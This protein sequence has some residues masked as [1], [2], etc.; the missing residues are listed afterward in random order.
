MNVIF[1][2]YLLNKIWQLLPEVF[3]NN[4]NII[5]IILKTSPDLTL[6]GLVMLKICNLLSSY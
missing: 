5:T 1:L 3:D 4:N 6:V 2:N